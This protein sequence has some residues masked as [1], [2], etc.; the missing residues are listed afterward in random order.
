MAGCMWFY[1][2]HVLIAYQQADAALNGRPRGNLSDLYPRWLGARELILHH[3]NPYSREITRE[4]QTGYYGRPIDPTRPEDPKDQQG[5]VYPVYVVFLLAPIIKAPFP[6]V[7]ECFRWTL[8]IVV[9][10]TVLFWLRALRWSPSLS[11]IGI[12]ILLTLS[13][14]PVLQGIKLQQLTLLVSGLIAASMVLI[15]YDHLLT[16][17]PLLA[18][19]TIKP[20]LVLLIIVWLLLW[21]LSNWQ[22]RRALVWSFVVSMALLLLGAQWILPGWITEFQKALSAYRQYTGPS[23][24]VL[25]VLMPAGWGSALTILILLGLA[26]TCWRVRGAPA[27][28]PLFVL[29]SSLVLTATVAAIPRTSPY[30]QILLLPGILFLVRYQHLWWR[31][32][33]VL[34]LVGIIA[35]ISVFWPWLV[36]LVLTIAGLLLPSATVQKAWAVPLWTS[37]AIP[38]LI[39]V[40]L[41]SLLIPHFSSDTL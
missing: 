27:D 18:I 36:A 39:A 14:F 20:Q 1:V 30:N 12:L 37:L 38:P 32:N 35:A 9:A 8:A 23:G 5:F 25:A 2:Q 19:A 29:T 22:S 15:S 33:I 41:A 6:I 40:L 28:N 24:S 3:R 21:A 11:S 17:G 13:S 31:G 4:I 7:Q 10:L 26:F 34:R 16:A